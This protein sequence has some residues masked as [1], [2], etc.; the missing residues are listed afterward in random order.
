MCLYSW[1]ENENYTYGFERVR[2]LSAFVQSVLLISF[3]SRGFVKSFLRVLWPTVIDMDGLLVTSL[4][5]LAVNILGVILL[6]TEDFGKA[7]YAL[8]RASFYC[9]Y[10]MF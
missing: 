10:R 8:A 2:T 5:G 9:P 4:I 1:K 6:Q 3:A 7:C